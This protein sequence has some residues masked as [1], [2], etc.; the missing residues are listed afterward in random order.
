MFFYELTQSIL[1]ELIIVF[2]PALAYA[3]RKDDEHVARPEVPEPPRI[4]AIETANRCNRKVHFD[5]Q[6]ACILS[7]GWELLE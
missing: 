6:L 1:A 4:R 7:D 3:V 5:D 2:S